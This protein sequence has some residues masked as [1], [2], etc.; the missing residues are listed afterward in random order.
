MTQGLEGPVEDAGGRWKLISWEYTAI[1]T[2]GLEPDPARIRAI[3]TF[4]AAYI[5]LLARRVYQS[6]NGGVEAFGYH[7]IGRHIPVLGPAD[8]GMEPVH[9]AAVPP[10]WPYATGTVYAMRT[11][12]LPWKK[13]SWQL[14]TGFPDLYL[15]HDDELVRW[16]RA[17][18][19][20]MHE[21]A[22]SIQASILRR[23]REEV[24]ADETELER[25]QQGRR[26]SLH[27]D[28]KELQDA[29]T[30][31]LHWMEHPQQRPALPEPKPF[32]DAPALREYPE[33]PIIGAS[34][35]TAPMEEGATP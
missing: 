3:R 22:E 5:P 8:E 14:R 21:A 15:P 19:H 20:D 11:W 35:A 26:D 4:D 28:R 34:P 10:P 27:D 16:M 13:G 18:Y 30:N 23:L 32:A 17:C 9:L 25:V 24:A 1:F 31:E 29:V 6:P 33:I 7:V 2:D 12:S